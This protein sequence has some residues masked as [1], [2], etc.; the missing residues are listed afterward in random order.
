MCPGLLSSWTQEP[1]LIVTILGS[2]TLDPADPGHGVLSSQPHLCPWCLQRD[3]GVQVWSGGPW[4]GPP[5]PALIDS[6]LFRKALGL[7]RQ[8]D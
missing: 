3:V 2:P 6:R 1:A 4:T 8:G 7:Q 5:L